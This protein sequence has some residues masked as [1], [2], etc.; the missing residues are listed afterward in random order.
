MRVRDRKPAL[1]TKELASRQPAANVLRSGDSR[2]SWCCS[3]KGRR[4]GT[5]VVVEGRE[6]SKNKASSTTTG[7]QSC[8]HPTPKNAGREMDSSSLFPRSCFSRSA[9]QSKRWSNTDVRVWMCLLVL[10][11]SLKEG[12]AEPLKLWSGV[13]IWSVLAGISESSW[14]FLGGGEI[15]EKNRSVERWGWGSDARPGHFLHR[16]QKYRPKAVAAVT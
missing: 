2:Y 11:K 3:V 12:R 16:V 7:Q 10:K 1:R 5:A 15:E 6:V 4:K 14:C 13:W 9:A 8:S